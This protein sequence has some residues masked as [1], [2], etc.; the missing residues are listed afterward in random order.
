MQGHK[1][2]PVDTVD[3]AHLVEIGPE[4]IGVA[5]RDLVPRHVA[6]RN[7]ADTGRLNR[8]DP[9]PERCVASDPDWVVD[10]GHPARRRHHVGH[11]GQF[12]LADRLREAPHRRHPRGRIGCLN[13]HRHGPVTDVDQGH[14]LAPSNVVCQSPT[15]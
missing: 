13:H 12:R 3:R 10:N 9:R 1:S 15:P 8:L 4:V 14:G 7:G 11:A 6:C 2:I 5:H